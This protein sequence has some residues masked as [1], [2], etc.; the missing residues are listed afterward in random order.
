MVRKLGKVLVLA[1]LL[2]ALAAAQ[3]PRYSAAANLS[4]VQQRLIDVTASGTTLTITAA[5]TTVYM[6]FA[7]GLSNTT[8]ISD[9]VVTGQLLTIVCNPAFTGNQPFQITADYAEFAAIQLGGSSYS[10][11]YDLG[12]TFVDTTQTACGAELMWDDVNGT[13]QLINLFG[14]QA[15]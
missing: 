2:S 6:N 7:A 8:A 9:G 15:N 4:S 5:P 14:G 1:W 12:G 11:S 3:F 13:W 10:G